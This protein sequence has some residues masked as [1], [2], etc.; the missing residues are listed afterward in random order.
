MST[1]EPEPPPLLSI[2]RI[3]DDHGLQRAEVRTLIHEHDICTRRLATATVVADAHWP[4]LERVVRRY[5]RTKRRRERRAAEAS[6]S[7]S[8]RPRLAGPVVRDS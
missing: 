5:C 4:R 2:T 8:A 6:A 3:A 7:A 1:A